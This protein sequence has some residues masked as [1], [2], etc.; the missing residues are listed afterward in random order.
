MIRYKPVRIKNPPLM[1][2]IVISS[3]IRMVAK[4]TVTNGSAKRNELV[5][6]ALECFIT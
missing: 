5:A 2:K 1:V 6:E 4:T 3:L